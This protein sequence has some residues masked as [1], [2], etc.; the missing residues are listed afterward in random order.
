[1]AKLP[2]CAYG[3]RIMRITIRGVVAVTILIQLIQLGAIIVLFLRG[4]GQTEEIQAKEIQTERLVIKARN[5]G[6]YAKLGTRELT[7]TARDGQTMEIYEP[8]L[9][10]FAHGDGQF[11]DCQIVADRSEGAHILLGAAN[12]RRQLDI[13]PWEERGFFFG[14]KD[15][16]GDGSISLALLFDVSN[17]T[18]R[19]IDSEKA[20]VLRI[21]LN[22]NG[23]K[24]EPTLTIYSDAPEIILRKS[25]SNK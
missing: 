2:P 22:S 13:G 20:D 8:R 14:S 25:R 1:M 7:V 19:L 5:G 9:D 21:T 23:K 18:I 15:I 4:N 17:G 12:G 3:E 10:L 6:V 11:P 16:G 24:V